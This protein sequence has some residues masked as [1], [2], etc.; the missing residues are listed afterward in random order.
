VTKRRRV[1]QLQR[2]H[3]EFADSS[4][5]PLPN[6]AL[7]P[8]QVLGRFEIGDRFTR[9]GN[10]DEMTRNFART[11]FGVDEMKKVAIAT[12]PTATFQA[13]I[14]AGKGVAED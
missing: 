13:K 7:Q 1:A 11:V 6:F 9:I 10:S 5:Q 12:R 14:N 3:F 2:L 4:A 8:N